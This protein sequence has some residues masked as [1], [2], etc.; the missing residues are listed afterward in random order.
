MRHSEGTFDADDGLTIFHRAWLPEGDQRAVVLLVHGLGEHSGR[1]HHVAERL[2][3]AGFA[4]HALDHR[5]HGRSEGA[6][7]FV[8]SYD[9]LMR[10]MVRFRA[11]VEE[12]HPGL[13]LVILGHSMGG[14][15]AMGHTLDHQ[16]G[17]AGLALSGAALRPVDELPGIQRT[18]L[19][20]LSKVAPQLRPQGLDLATL[21]RDPEVVAAYHAD[22]LVHA[23][24]V[25]VGLAAALF[26][27]MDRFPE[28]YDTL[29]VPIWIGHGTADRLTAVDGSRELA[30][31][32][33]NAEVTAHYYD[34]LY[35]EIFNEP[36][37]DRVLDDLVAWLDGVVG[38]RA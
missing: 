19:R 14:N 23:G 10:D 7:A 28:R 29:T 20:V 12:Q 5:G 37:R 9:E 4:V 35:H 17:V 6:R 13:P 30:A 18:A 38:A 26:G 11:L 33:T 22:P 31:R 36:E 16:D 2:V 24:K 34:G 21:S 27:A 25:P 15:I 1:Y 8:R 3:D 32:A